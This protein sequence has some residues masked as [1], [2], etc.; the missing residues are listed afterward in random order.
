MA[1]QKLVNLR[2][3]DMASEDDVDGV[4]HELFPCNDGEPPPVVT[5]I[6]VTRMENNNRV[7]SP[8]MFMAEELP[9][10]ATLCSRY[11]GGHYELLAR[12][13]NR[14]TSRAKYYIPGPSLPMFDAVTPPVEE[15][16]APAMLVA[17]PMQG[18]SDTAMMMQMFM[19][20]MQTMAQSQSQ[21]MLAMMNG[22]GDRSK[23][24]VQSMQALHDRHAAESSNATQNMLMMVKEMAAS[25]SSGGEDSNNFFKGVEFMRNFTQSQ[26]EMAKASAAG[27]G[28]D[29]LDGLLGTLMQAVQGFSAFQGAT[30]PSPTPG[31]PITE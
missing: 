18:N 30:S 27:S 12:H 22:S 29:G 9:N 23:E 5:Q 31:L 17:Q 8:Y 15:K 16:A 24:Y 3:F 4:A 20:M 19:T 7:F 26:I 11:G 6:Q 25:K 1:K 10:L 28:E 14:I 2:D 13:N 21:M